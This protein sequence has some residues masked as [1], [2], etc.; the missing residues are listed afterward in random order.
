MTVFEKIATGELESYVVAETDDFMAI[1][2][3]FPLREGQVVLFPK[4]RAPSQLTSVNADM[5]QSAVSFAQQVAQ[6]MESKLDNVLR[7]VMMIEGLEIDH[8]HIKLFP[9]YR[10]DVHGLTP[11]SPQAD[12]G[13]LESIHLQLT[14]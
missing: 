4:R 2:D 11:G 14:D 8:F 5:L 6:Q 3:L 7:V 10:D 13:R 12:T 1:L 9:V